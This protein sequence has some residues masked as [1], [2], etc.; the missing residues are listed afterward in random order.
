MSR[1][2]KRGKPT[3]VWTASQFVED[4]HWSA[5]T[6]GIPEIPIISVPECFT[7][8][9]PERVATMVEAQIDAVVRG[10]TSDPDH[11][12][13]HFEHITRV[14]AATLSYE[15]SDLMDCFDRMQEAFTKAGWSDGLPLIPPTR[16]K[17]DAMIA[18]CGLP[19]DHVVGIFE[20]GFGIGT[21]EK[22]A[23]NA[24]MAGCK[25]DAMPIILAMADA[26]L[27]PKSRLRSFSMSTGPQAPLVLV[28]GPYA[29]AIGM[30]SGICALG[31]GSISQ[32]NVA[33]GRTLRL[34][35][36]NV[37]HSYPGVSDMDTI[38]SS[39]KFGACVAENEAR[40]PWVPFREYQGFAKTAT[41]VTVVVPYGVCEVWD[42]RNYDPEAMIDVYGSAIRNGA[43]VNS[44]GWLTAS[45]EGHA[46]GGAGSAQVRNPI[47][48]CPDHAAVFGRA[49][50]SL[51]RV[52]QAL[53][54]SAR[55]PFGELMANK[56]PANFRMSHPDKQWMWDKPETL[57]PLFRGPQDFEIF[58][59]GGDAG[60]SLYFYGGGDS[61]TR[62]VKVK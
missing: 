44:G 54:E 22:L 6:F 11:V 14:E 7:N 50:W 9:S 38:G 30:N 37:G 43:Q 33:I 55:L 57:L 1:F 4:A 36:M 24:V 32:V 29:A 47:L 46:D 49:G 23:A 53:F 8:N 19:A 21:V 5:K 60:R 25:P 58:V 15:G 56:E 31:P 27:D 62:E 3:V 61:M 18:G 28:S 34:L 17:V 10:L 12:E 45:P 39:M 16:A 41:T 20:P 52:Q 2:E 48:M 13:V 40:N 26:C 51:E 42:F 59:V 35:M